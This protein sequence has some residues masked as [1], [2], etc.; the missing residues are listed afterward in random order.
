MTVFFKET[1]DGTLATIG[2]D[3]NVKK[4]RPLL[5]FHPACDRNYPS[6]WQLLLDIGAEFIHICN[7]I[8][9]VYPEMFRHE[10]GYQYFTRFGDMN[11]YEGQVYHNSQL[12]INHRQIHIE[13]DARQTLDTLPLVDIYYDDYPHALF[14]E[15]G[16]D[17]KSYLE[18][19]SEN[20]VD[21]G[22]LIFDLKNFQHSN[23]VENWS[24][25]LKQESLGGKVEYLGR[26]EWLNLTDIAIHNSS[27]AYV[28][29][30]HN[31][32]EKSVQFSDW[33]KGVI[34]EYSCRNWL[35]SNI[36]SRSVQKFSHIH[37]VS[38]DH[39]QEMWRNHIEYGSP[40][41]SDY[42]AFET[43][44]LDY[45][46][47]GKSIKR[48]E[49]KYLDDLIK[50]YENKPGI[51][52]VKADIFDHLHW[53]WLN[54]Y[55]VILRDKHEKK[56]RRICP[57][58][59]QKL[60]SVSSNQYL[61][62]KIGWSGEESNAFKAIENKLQMIDC[63]RVATIIFGNGELPTKTNSSKFDELLVFHIDDEI[64]A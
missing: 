32:K 17:V 34:P 42:P 54:N 52:T 64:I 36:S 16:M 24:Y 46:E 18:K 1:T 8:G 37:S 13:G 59:G 31:E 6:S 40:M 12:K 57:M 60:I 20:I 22:L 7:D 2:L 33:V 3:V 5:L 50:K 44:V 51:K 14:Y 11:R 63:S 41:W 38:P 19:V 28:F 23:E 15:G 27:T 49:Q 61:N 35:F 55:T 9:P 56:A 47:Y 39:Y 53:L 45:V 25:K 58:L 10:S 43:S 30:I 26:A 29:K 48:G 62:S 4:D 21:G